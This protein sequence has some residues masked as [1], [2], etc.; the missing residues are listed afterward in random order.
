MV[1]QSTEIIPISTADKLGRLGF[2]IGKSEYRMQFGKLL[3]DGITLTCKQL[4]EPEFQPMLR[5]M[6]E[7]KSE[8][9]V[10][11]SKK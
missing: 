9:I 11:S 10:K 3:I 5:K 4:L 2:S 1:E 7:E 8:L 6:L